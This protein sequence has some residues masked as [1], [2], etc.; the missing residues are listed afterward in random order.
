MPKNQYREM[1]GSSGKTSQQGQL[2]TMGRVITRTP[3]AK[4]ATGIYD[5]HPSP[6]LADYP[7]SVGPGDISTKFAETGIGDANTQTNQL[8][9]SKGVSRKGKASPISSSNMNKKKN[10]Y[11]TY[12]KTKQ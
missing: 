12:G 1:T 2:R 3:A 8:R 11:R 5:H 6:G 10:P 4:G 9:Q 7:A